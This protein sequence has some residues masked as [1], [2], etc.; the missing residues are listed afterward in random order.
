MSKNSRN[1]RNAFAIRLKPTK[2][3][4]LQALLGGAKE[5]AVEKVPA[6]KPRGRAARQIQARDQPVRKCTCNKRGR[7]LNRRGE[8]NRCGKKP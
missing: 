7:T 5:K 2:K 4:Q 1:L 3:E 8:C 6:R